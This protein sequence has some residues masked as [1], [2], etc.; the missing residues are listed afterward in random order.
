MIF[1]IQD[2][3]NREYLSNREITNHKSQRISLQNRRRGV[4]HVTLE[5]PSYMEKQKKKST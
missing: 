5:I 2:T 3:E 1:N 4:V